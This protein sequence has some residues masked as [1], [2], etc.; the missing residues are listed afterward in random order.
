MSV[1]VK[2]KTQILSFWSTQPHGEDGQYRNISA[3]LGGN[4]SEEEDD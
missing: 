1:R 3:M 4:S 2:T